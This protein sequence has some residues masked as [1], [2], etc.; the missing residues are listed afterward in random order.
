[1]QIHIGHLL[2]CLNLTNKFFSLIC[3]TF[4][5]RS[6]FCSIL[7]ASPEDRISYSRYC[8]LQKK[9]NQKLCVDRQTLFENFFLTTEERK[10][11]R[12]RREEFSKFIFFFNDG[13]YTN[14]IWF[15][16]VKTISY[17][18]WLW[19]NR[20]I[21]AHFVSCSSKQQL[22]MFWCYPTFSRKKINISRSSSRIVF[23]CRKIPCEK[24]VTDANKVSLFDTV[25]IH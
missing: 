18:I 11:R 21:T 5:C 24:S 8:Y 7:S 1:M 10:K 6:F 3:S 23:F 2:Q 25:N 20:L 22:D 13:S 16:V 15:S 19:E 9:N 12:F 4:F 17:L 14:V